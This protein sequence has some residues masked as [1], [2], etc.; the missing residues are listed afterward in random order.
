[1]TPPTYEVSKATITNREQRSATGEC[2]ILLELRQ[3]GAK[4]LPVRLESDGIIQTHVTM[5][6]SVMCVVDF[7]L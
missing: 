2:Y 4:A 7:C 3:F 6:P 1:M 5:T